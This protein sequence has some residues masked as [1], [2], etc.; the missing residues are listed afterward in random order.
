M[1]SPGLLV[2]ECCRFATGIALLTG[3][4]R[5]SAGDAGAALR[6]AKLLDLP[7]IETAP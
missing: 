3:E 2:D 7:P 5:D 1:V 6:L 4:L